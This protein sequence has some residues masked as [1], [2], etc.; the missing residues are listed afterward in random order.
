VDKPSLTTFA[1]RQEDPLASARPPG[2]NA[3]MSQ[4]HDDYA[5][6]GS[7]PPYSWVREAAAWLLVPAV[8]FTVGLVIVSAGWVLSLLL[9]IND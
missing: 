2:Q 7:P 1:S 9:R 4:E 3:G 6:N 5:E 8:L